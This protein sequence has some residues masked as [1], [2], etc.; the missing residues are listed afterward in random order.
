M[1]AE[2]IRL[3]AQPT[4]LVGRDEDLRAIRALIDR[5]HRRLVTLTG[6]GGTGKTRLAIAAATHLADLF[7][8]GV[9]FVDLSALRDA[10]LVPAAI[11]QQVE[12]RTDHD[13]KAAILRAIGDRRM[14]LVLDNF[15]QVVDAA[16]TVAELLGACAGLAIIATSRRPLDVRW[17]SE[18]P[19]G[20]LAAPDAVALF[21]DR[22]RDADPNLG[23]GRDTRE[24][25]A[26]ICDQL[27]R[28]PLAI[29]LAAARV[30]TVPPRL[31]RAQLEHRL[32]FLDSGPRDL[33]ERHR[34][35]ANTVAWSYDLLSEE[36]QRL[37]RELCVFVGG[38]TES[39]A[40]AVLDLPAA[41]VRDALGFLVECSLLQLVEHGPQRR[42]AML[43]TVREFGAERAGDDRRLRRRHAEYFAALAERAEPE[44]WGPDQVA[45]YRDL[46]REH[47]NARAALAWTIEHREADLALRLVAALWTLWFTQGYLAEGA[48]WME[49]ALRLAGWTSARHRAFAALHAGDLLSARGDHESASALIAEARALF[50]ELHDDAG[51]R[52]AMESE[53][54][55][56][57]ERGQ[58]DHA[59]SVYEAL[60]DLALAA[61]DGD[62]LATATRNLASVKRGEGDLAA[63]ERLYEE[64]L[65]LLAAV[66]RTRHIAHVLQYL[67]HLVQ[68]RG[69]L[70]RAVDLSRQSLERFQELGGIRCFGEEL[71]DIGLL[72]ARAGHAERALRLL[73]AAANVRDQIDLALTVLEQ[74]ENDEVVTA[75]R[76]AVGRDSERVFSEGR[77]MRVEDALEYARD[78]LDSIGGPAPSRA[79]MPPISLEAQLRREGEIWSVNFA[80]QSTRLQDSKGLR[81]LAR[82]LRE[83][84]RE[85]HALDLAGAPQAPAAGPAR[86]EAIDPAAR[87][88]YRER[89]R[90]LDE[91][92][93]EA[94]RF[95]DSER[96]ARARSEREFI[97]AE[98]AAAFGIGGKA[99]TA[100]TDA[101][102]AR[103]AVTKAIKAALARIAE[104]SPTLGRHL[105]ATIHTGAFCSYT[106]DPR[107]P[108]TWQT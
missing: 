102:R 39:A 36:D 89:L 19:V 75:A 100:A 86:I 4:A 31:M 11:A 76:S 1:A 41:S 69:D 68:R 90:E 73:G 47:D 105:D 81:Y 49:Q 98:L 60:R 14:L 44:L 62:V 108:I 45:R 87:A 12:V 28:L 96:A 93:G 6:P 26:G 56:A 106:P 23:L 13:A 88:A 66:G 27:D 53:G 74:H 34:K 79:A 82:L 3:P 64:S 22:A 24:A 72:V 51:V 17:E 21:L 38:F 103:V 101:E 77:A 83:P 20:P 52:Q 32:A 35:L 80:G 5:D 94:E 54:F 10:A 25:V 16:P 91:E 8:D 85:F 40:R 65:P 107:A 63:A 61:G 104:A 59:A 46:E 97:A 33:P 48:R 42:F 58:W 67:A 37:F 84:G 95:G 18:R 15:E 30:R 29:E 78:T 7:P 50:E 70:E 99:R 2:S 9:R 57:M 43:E 92:E 55:T 71:Q